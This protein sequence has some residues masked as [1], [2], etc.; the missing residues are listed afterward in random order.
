M[1]IPDNETPTRFIYYSVYSIP[2][3]YTFI[4]VMLIQ[5][6]VAILTSVKEGNAM[7]EV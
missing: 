3:A 1:F 5:D 6:N 4:T 7:W 2:Y